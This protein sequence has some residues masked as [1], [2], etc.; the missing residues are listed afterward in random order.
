M[1][2]LSALSW[3]LRPEYAGVCS[4]CLLVGGAFDMGSL[5]C[6]VC[7]LLCFVSV[8]CFYFWVF[9]LLI[10]STYCLSFF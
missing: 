3:C 2:G 7:L 4:V 9:R 10:L 1:S 5:M 8:S 6:S